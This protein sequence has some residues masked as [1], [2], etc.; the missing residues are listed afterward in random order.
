M[1][2]I[3]GGEGQS[4]LRGAQLLAMLLRDQASHAERQL[5]AAP[6]RAVLALPV[7]LGADGVR[8]AADAAAI[9]RLGETRLASSAA[10]LAYHYA[11][12]HST[13]L[14]PALDARSG[15]AAGGTDAPAPEQE[16]RETTVLLVDVGHLASSAAVA[17]FTQGV[18]GAASAALLASHGSFAVGAGVVDD[19]L[20]RCAPAPALR[21]LGWGCALSSEPHGACA[22]GT[23]R[24]SWQASTARTLAPAP[25]SSCACGAPARASRRCSPQSIRPRC[26]SGARPALSDPPRAQPPRPSHRTT[27]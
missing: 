10:A 2:S 21:T 14:F 20:M 26:R 25:S 16:A 23:L 7:A 9:A 3:H 27:C 8:A 19:A 13:D 4:E 5:G 18:D 24:R 12:R 6:A 15:G 1:P 11:E 17:R 22:A